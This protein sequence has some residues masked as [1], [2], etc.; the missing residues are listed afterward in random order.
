MLCLGL[1]VTPVSFSSACSFLRGDYDIKLTANSC[2]ALQFNKRGQLFIRA[3]NETLAA[4]AVVVV[5]IVRSI[6][7]YKPPI[8][9]PE[10]RRAF[11]QRAQ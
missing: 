2:I 10:T 1:A 9:I 3:H 6:G 5:S 8:P 4:I 11:R 7:G